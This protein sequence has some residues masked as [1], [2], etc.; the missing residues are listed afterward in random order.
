MAKS[1]KRK[2]KSSA[3]KNVAIFFIVFTL[4]VGLLIFGLKSVFKND[5][6]VATLAGYSF[7]IMDSD[8]MGQDC[9]KDSLVIAVNGVPSSEKCGLPMLAKNVEGFGTTVG[10]LYEVGSKGDTVDYAVYT[11]YQ[12][13]APDKMY[14]LKSSDIVGQATSYY[15]T[16]GKIISFMITPFGMAVCLAAPIVLMILI[17]LIIAMANR[18]GDGY[19]LEDFEE[20]ERLHDAQQ[21]SNMS[22]DDFLYGG[23]GDEVYSSAGKPSADYEEEFDENYS[24]PAS[25]ENSISKEADLFFGIGQETA[26]E[27]PEEPV[28]EE[29]PF[30]EEPEP[31]AEPEPEPVEEAEEEDDDTPIIPHELFAHKKSAPEPEPVAEPE[32][33]PV[34][35]SGASVDPSYY[36]KASKM[37]D[38]AVDSHDAVEASAPVSS[39]EDTSYEEPVRRP[40][41]PQQRPA[42]GQRRRPPQRP[43][44]APPRRRPPQRPRREETGKNSAATID[45]LMKLM[46]EEQK[47]LRNP[48]KD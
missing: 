31:V 7:F 37:I 13:K 4:L 32:P 27:E 25:D 41:R 21:N 22:L 46:E 29:E 10:W 12:E 42:Q 19:D 6:S 35:E 33:E 1:R 24:E 28:Q 3:A 9:P 5:D 39:A 23:E 30:F 36:E 48:G 15:L 43:A 18:S 38:D 11:I 17:L 45:E 44:G 14:D 40:Q 20:M 47:K 26:D 8:N 2:K 16:A 34:D